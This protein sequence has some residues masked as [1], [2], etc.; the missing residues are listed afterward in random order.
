MTSKSATSPADSD[1]WLSLLYEPKS[2][3]IVG[4]SEDIKAPGGRLLR[5]MLN[6]GFSGEIYAVNPK[7]ATVQGVAAFPSVADLPARPD[8]AAIVVTATQAVEALEQCGVLGIPMVMIGSAGFAET[9]AKGAELQA[10]LAAIAKKYGMR[11]LG[12]NTSGIINSRNGLAL[13]FTPSLDQQ[14]LKLPDGRVAIVS[15]SGAIGAALFY[16]GLLAG[17]PVTR[18]LNTGNEL[19]ISL[20]AA[21]DALAGPTSGID[22]ILCYVEGLRHADAF[23]KA[24]RRA[25]EQ[26]A[27]IVVLKTGSSAA[28]AEAAAA[29]TASLAGEDRV[30]T[31]VLRQLG[32]ARAHGMSHLLDTGRVLAAYGSEIGTRASIVSISGGAGIILTDALENVGMRAATLPKASQDAIDPFV[33]AFLARKNPLDVGG[34]PFHDLSKLRQILQVLDQNPGSDMSIVAVGSFERRQL[35]IAQAMI[36]EAPNL[37]KPLFAVWFGGGDEATKLLNVSGIPCFHDPLHLIDAIA[38]ARE[39]RP[40]AGRLSAVRNPSSADDVAAAKKIFAEA[41][42]A[43]RRVLDEVDGKRVLRAFGMDVVAECVVAGPEQCEAAVAGFR[44]PVVA[45]L[46]SDE[47]VHKAR[48][49]GVRLG[50][51]SVAELRT[52]T[53]ELLALARQLNVKVA[54]IVVQE[55]V[56][57]GVE[58]LL[59]M[60][61][62]PTFGPVITLGIGGVLAEV[63]DDVQIKLAA[64][65]ENEVPDMLAGLRHQKL[66][67]GGHGGAAVDPAVVTRAVTGFCRLVAAVGDEIDAIDVNPLIL[68]PASKSAIAVD[69]VFFLRD[70]ASK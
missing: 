47:I 2:V 55:Q 14:G 32:V 17:L 5:Y 54:D 60:K 68:N 27:K 25:H 12:P 8:L 29:H 43:G 1:N 6:Y 46:R 13:S 70:H 45:K 22:I 65:C 11:L 19:D 18:L 37:K 57:S 51:R 59:G 30:Y 34:G 10:Q 63:W 53:G 31:G 61:R 48:V 69:A 4:A 58:L 20:E 26:G 40:P 44:W 62:D 35:E 9:G 49:G 36:D 67:E 50:L 64:D 24:A 28:G 16:D 42:A 3:V 56:E 33:P 23:A 38:S 7:R 66:L 21:V 41:R 52:A 15:Q 39:C